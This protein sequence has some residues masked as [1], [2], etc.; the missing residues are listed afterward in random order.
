MQ[1]RHPVRLMAVI[2]TASLCLSPLQT[3]AFASSAETADQDQVNEEVT[4][5]TTDENSEQSSDERTPVPDA[6]ESIPE[7]DLSSEVSSEVET[8]TVNTSE[9]ENSENV[10]SVDD[11]EDADLSGADNSESAIDSNVS[12]EMEGNTAA[13][14]SGEDAD[15]SSMDVV[16]EISEQREEA[17]F[18]EN[19]NPEDLFAQ[20]ADIRFFGEMPDTTAP[21]RKKSKKATGTRLKGHNLILYNA[22]HEAAVEIAAGNLAETQVEVPISAFGIDPGKHYTAE[23]LGLSYI[24]DIENEEVNPELQTAMM[25]VF[26]YDISAV[27][28]SLRADFPYEFYWQSGGF[29]Y[30][31]ALGMS[32]NSREAWFTA[33]VIKIGMPVESKYRLNGQ[34]FVADTVKTGAVSVA[35]ENVTLCFPS[36]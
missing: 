10:E 36:Q 3:I 35:V 34:K 11:S 2:L 17:E 20:Y 26:E 33:D 7:T 15:S 16:L 8:G 6:G 24:Y 5:E 1:R 29:T 18:E 31:S 32:L 21:I 14:T 12:V 27:S 23:E 22:L 19:Y 9:L 4:D 30:P 25:S 13:G 28:H